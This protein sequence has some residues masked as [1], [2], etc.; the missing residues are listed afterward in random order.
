MTISYAEYN[1][2]GNFFQNLRS[3]VRKLG[4][5]GNKVLSGP[6]GTGLRAAFPE[7][8]PLIE[9]VHQASKMA[10]GAGRRRLR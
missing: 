8:S 9:G 4:G 7:F 1:G 2:G 10:Q 3:F 5:F 6:I